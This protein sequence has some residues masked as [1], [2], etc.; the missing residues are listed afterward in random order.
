MKKSLF[1]LSVLTLMALLLSSCSLFMPGPV[2]YTEQPGESTEVLQSETSAAAEPAETTEKTPETTAAETTVEAAAETT[3]AETTV[4]ATTETTAAETT[5]A[6]TTQAFAGEIPP[7]APAL[8]TGFLKGPTAMG[9]AKVMKEGPGIACS[10]LILNAPDELASAFL[11]GEFDIAALPANLAAVLYN[12]TQGKVKVLAINTL[13]VLYITGQDESIKTIADLKG[14]TVYASG[15]G[16]TP[17]FVFNELLKKNGLDPAKD[18]TV[19]W[20]SEHSECVGALAQNPDAVALLPQ[21]FVTVAMNKIKGLKILIDMNKEWAEV[22]DGKPLVTGVLAVRSEFAEQWPQLVNT[23]LNAYQASVAYANN[24]PDGAATLIG[25]YG[26]VPEAVALKALPYCN[27][28]CISGPEMKAQLEVYYK[29]L[30]D[31]EP[32]S[33][34]GKLPGDDFFYMP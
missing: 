31:Q 21:P 26:I 16:A 15:K 34:G 30:F 27:I 14:K 11:K 1:I 2:M 20:K 7:G 19:E 6:A 17:E 18:V 5:I 12:K 3:A 13:G 9:A 28:V 25:S 32:K 24:D 4:E 23:Y 29:V 22:E 33:V 8:R 10:A